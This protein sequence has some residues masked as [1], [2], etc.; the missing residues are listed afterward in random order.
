MKF[1]RFIGNS[2]LANNEVALYENGAGFTLRAETVRGGKVLHDFET[3]MGKGRAVLT[4]IHLSKEDLGQ[5]EERWEAG[6]QGAATPESLSGRCPT[7]NRCLWIGTPADCPPLQ[8]KENTLP[9]KIL[10][11]KEWSDYCQELD[12]KFGI[13]QIFAGGLWC[14]EEELINPAT[15]AANFTPTADPEAVAKAEAYCNEPVRAAGFTRLGIKA[16][17]FVDALNDLC[18]EHGVQ[19]SGHGPVYIQNLLPHEEPI[20]F[21]EIQDRT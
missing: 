16:E 11:A 7:W 19:M 4:D 15:A 18:H 14:R 20:D 3:P 2:A 9:S 10:T 8:T 5:L 12:Q 17:A 13:S 6:T 1:I 21:P